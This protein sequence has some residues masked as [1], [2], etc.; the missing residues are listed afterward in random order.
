[1]TDQYAEIAQQYKKS[2]HQPWRLFIEDFTLFQL[3]GEISGKSILDLACG[4]GWY[5]R[6]LKKHGAGRVVGVDLSAP[7]IALAQAEESR[8]PLGIEYVHEDAA[9]FVSAEP[10][11]LVVAVY[12]L[13]YAR[14]AEQLLS[15][16]HSV[17]RAL[18]P[19]GRFVAVNNHL[20]QPIEAFPATAKYGLVKSFAEPIREGTPITYTLTTDGESI[21]FDNYYLSPTTYEE[22]FQRAGLQTLRWHAPQ[23]S[24]LGVEEYG[25][26]YWDDFL[27]QPPVYFLECVRSD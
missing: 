18:K 26:D 13:N 21:S 24:P 6:R 17:S 22:T 1:M 14:T 20:E 10:F 9:R 7:M 8:E 11:D 23:L 3:I 16:V 5:T 27:R 12:L 19:G 4:E 2:K 25:R 15:M